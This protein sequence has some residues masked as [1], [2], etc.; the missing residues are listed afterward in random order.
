MHLI[1][2]FFAVLVIGIAL[3]AVIKPILKTASRITELSRDLGMDLSMAGAGGAM[4][5]TGQ[6]QGK[7]IHYSLRTGNAR[8]PP[9]IVVTLEHSS[10]LKITLRPQT[11]ITELKVSFGTGR[12]LQIGVPELDER[13]EI[14]AADQDPIHRFFRHAK[15]RD[16]LRS[17]DQKRFEM[18]A[19]NPQ[20]LIYKEKID[21]SQISASYLRKL[22]KTLL[23]IVELA[24]LIAK[25]SAKKP[26]APQAAATGGAGA[27]AGSFPPETAATATSAANERNAVSASVP[28]SKER[29]AVAPSA[30]AVKD[31]KAVA[32]SATAAPAAPAAPPATAACAA[33]APGAAPAAAAAAAPAQQED[34]GGSPATAAQADTDTLLRR[35]GSGELVPETFAELVAAQGEAAIGRCVDKLSD[36][37]LRDRLK[38]ALAAMGAQALDPMLEKSGDFMVSYEIREVLS[39]MDRQAVTGLGTALTR[40]EDEKILEFVL[41]AIGRLGLTEA[42]DQVVSYLSHDAMTV[43]FQAKRTLSQLG[44]ESD[45]IDKLRDKADE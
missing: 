24:G 7:P 13:Y 14:D 9:E 11:D 15:V 6:V 18:L 36:Y 31:R 38:P 41:D 1:L 25:Q 22:N 26:G 45:A 8:R 16:I 19:L 33:A 39:A 12:D 10:P 5:F 37:N 23:R 27:E 28:A 21:Q 35:L 32:P 43:R 29:K 40:F 20:N 4:R 44:M 34:F 3:I 17:F 42:Q 2:I 30:P